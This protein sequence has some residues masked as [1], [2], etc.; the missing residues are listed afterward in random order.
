MDVVLNDL[1]KENVTKDQLLVVIWE[2]L[3]FL[4]IAT[5]CAEK[6]A[7]KVVRLP[8]KARP[9]SFLNYYCTSRRACWCSAGSRC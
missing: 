8:R 4:M 3:C 9:F 2:F 5:A 1:G 6:W 7:N